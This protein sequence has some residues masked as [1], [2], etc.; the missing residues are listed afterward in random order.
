MSPTF[1]Y[2]FFSNFSHKKKIY[3]FLLVLKA[4][5]KMFFFDC[6]FCCHFLNLL[7]SNTRLVFRNWNKFPQANFR[8]VDP[9]NFDLNPDQQIRFVK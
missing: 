5:F 6:R 2:S 9:F 7:V 4:R 8:S 3:V 1:H